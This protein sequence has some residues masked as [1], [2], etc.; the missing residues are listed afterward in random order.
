[1]L[2]RPKHISRRIAKKNTEARKKKYTFLSES[3]IE[4]DTVLVQKAALK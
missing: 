4:P 3:D 2:Y 1:M